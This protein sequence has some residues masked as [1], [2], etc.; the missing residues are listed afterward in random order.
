MSHSC[1]R[2]SVPRASQTAELRNDARASGV[3]DRRRTD[4]ELAAAE[5]SRLAAL[6][7]Q[8]LRRMRQRGSGAPKA[9]ALIQS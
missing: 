5:A 9:T 6:E 7:R 2:L 8:R 1:L 3:A 4:A